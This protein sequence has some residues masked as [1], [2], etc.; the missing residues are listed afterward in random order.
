MR[1][2]VSIGEN[3]AHVFEVFQQAEQG[4]DR[5]RRPWPRPCAGQGLATLHKGT[6]SVTSDGLGAQA[7]LDANCWSIIL[8]S[9]W[10]S[11]RNTCRRRKVSTAHSFDRGRFRRRRNHAH[12]P[13][14]GRAKFTLPIP[15]CR[16]QAAMISSRCH[17]VRYRPARDPMAIRWSSACEPCFVGRIALTG[18]GR[19]RPAGA[20]AKR[21]SMY[22]GRS[23]PSAATRQLPGRAAAS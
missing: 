19:E 22:S 8:L 12:D 9:M 3:A 15:A 13:R 20:E 10:Q 6:V 21:P 16:R 5:A 18:Y 1:P 14:R 4:L 7:I 2:G 11:F 17:S 23:F